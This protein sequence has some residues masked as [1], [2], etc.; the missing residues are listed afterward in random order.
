M[1]PANHA[2]KTAQRKSPQASEGT[3]AG[4]TPRG[5]SGRPL[6]ERE[7]G[8]KGRA[9]LPEEAVDLR[10][11]PDVVG[12]DDA[13]DVGGDAGLPEDLVAAHRPVERGLPAARQAIAVVEIP[14]AV[15]AEADGEPFLRQ[16]P[17]PLPVEERA[18]GLQAVGDR[19]ARRT[20]PAFDRDDPAEVT[21][22][23]DRR[24]AAVPGEADDLVGRGGD[25]LGDIG[26]EEVFG[27]AG[28][29]VPGLPRRAPAQVVAIAAGQIAGRSRRL[30]ERPAPGRGC[31]SSGSQLQSRR[32]DENLEP[33]RPVDHR[34]DFIIP[35]NFML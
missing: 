14:R 31:S 17:A 6:D 35:G 22:A 4:L 7:E 34:R 1:S 28:R 2:S 26:L 3:E 24:L 5:A 23:Q 21:D 30:D 25:V 29:L 11:M 13:E 33:A 15:E 16:E 9:D 20:E 18:V 10:G 8:H 12:A 19:P 32:L 27:H